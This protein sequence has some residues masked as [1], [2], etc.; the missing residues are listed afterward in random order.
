MS[1]DPI[2]VLVVDDEA[3]LRETLE[4]A[5][6][7]AG[8]RVEL[9]DRAKA[10]LARVAEGGIDV[11]VTDVRMPELSGIDLLR[12]LRRLDHDVEVIVMT[13]F[14]RAE[15]AVEVMKAGAYD[16]LIKPFNLEELRVLVARAAERRR[17]DRENRRLRE[18]LSARRD[19]FVAASE[20]MRRVRLVAERV[21]AV[22]STV[23]ITG[24]SGVG[25]EVVA[26]FIHQAS[27]R[28]EGAFV[29]VNCGALPENLVES[30]LFGFEKGAF[31]GADRAR[32][33]LL[34]QASGGTVFLDE[35]GE[36]PLSAQVKLLRVLQEQRI[37][38]IGGQDERELDVRF[39]AATNRLLEEQVREGT[40]REDL[41]YRLNVV[42]IE[43]P[44][45][46]ER[47]EDLEILVPL[48]ARTAGIRLGLPVDEIDAGVVR[49][50][51][52]REFPGNVR[53]LQNII[54]RAVI[55]SGGGRLTVDDL[56]PETGGFGGAGGEPRAVLSPGFSLDAWLDEQEGRWLRAALEAAGG[57]K[58]K[59]ADLLGMTFRQFRYKARKHGL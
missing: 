12:E 17:L 25:K 40:F 42:R 7:R 43:I 57:V 1:Q 48:L 59:A 16:Y 32:A 36:L 52:A 23:L 45:L 30:E 41:F 5:L 15:D 14:A 46:R 31:T 54:E 28:A 53:E 50:L 20:A 2:S 51:A 35:V 34:E 18:A 21:A 26:R 10:A 11:V 58:T 24:E 39:I 33:G 56:P 8:F 44:P 49:V 9:A 38:R 13:A 19:E 3:S 55:M 47:P 6:V 27:R 4:I 22:D 29:A 37:R